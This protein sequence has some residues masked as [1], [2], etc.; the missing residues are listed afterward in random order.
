[1]I[2]KSINLPMQTFKCHQVPRHPFKQHGS[3]HTVMEW[4]HALKNVGLEHD[5]FA[6]FEQLSVIARTR[7]GYGRVNMTYHL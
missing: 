2:D 4:G 1:M 5:I 3:L 6:H 7:V